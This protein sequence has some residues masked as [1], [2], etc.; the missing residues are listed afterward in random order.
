MSDHEVTLSLQSCSPPLGLPG[1]RWDTKGRKTACEMEAPHPES[2]CSRL[3]PEMPAGSGVYISRTPCSGGQ[4]VRKYSHLQTG[5]QDSTSGQ[6][7]L[8]TQGETG[9][10]LGGDCRQHKMEQGDITC[11]NMRPGS[12]PFRPCPAAPSTM[13]PVWR[14]GKTGLEA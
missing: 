2:A 10:V 8:G 9:G 14:S 11:S 6:T 12:S 4:G 5:V 1:P 13:A 7:V 3:I